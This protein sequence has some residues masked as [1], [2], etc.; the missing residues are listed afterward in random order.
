MFDNYH[1]L[2]ITNTIRVNNG[3][4]IN[5]ASEDIKF[6]EEKLQKLLYN[7]INE[8]NMKLIIFLIFLPFPFVPYIINYVFEKYKKKTIILKDYYKYFWIVLIFDLVYIYYKWND[9]KYGIRSVQCAINNLDLALNNDKYID[10]NK[11][12]FNEGNYKTKY[13]GDDIKKYGIHATFCEIPGT[14]PSNNAKPSSFSYSIGGFC[15]NYDS[16]RRYFDKEADDYIGDEV[17]QKYRTLQ[18]NK[19]FDLF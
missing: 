5:I 15:Y 1:C 10:Y 13:I 6:F 4:I 8:F 16:Q 9:Y 12:N 18:I 7:L 14:L 2:G 19:T 17:S 3:Y 11:S